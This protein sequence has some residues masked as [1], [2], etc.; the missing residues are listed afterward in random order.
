MN[1]NEGV[2]D[3]TRESGWGLCHRLE[4]VSEEAGIS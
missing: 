2:E 3:Y 4:A 1:T